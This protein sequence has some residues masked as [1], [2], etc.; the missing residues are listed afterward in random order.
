MFSPSTFN[1]ENFILKVSAIVF[2]IY[3]GAILLCIGSKP[4]MYTFEYNSV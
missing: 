2:D 4:L 3:V 1:I